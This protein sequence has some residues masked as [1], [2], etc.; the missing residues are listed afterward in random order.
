[1]GELGGGA[2]STRSHRLAV[3]RSMFRALVAEGVLT[4]NPAQAVRCERAVA[5]SVK[6]HVPVPRGQLIKVLAKLG[7]DERGRRDRALLLV[8]ANCGLR[9]SEVAELTVSSIERNGEDAALLVH[10]KGG[11]VDRL[12]LKP[13]T[14]GALEKW[15]EVSGGKDAPDG[16]LFRN[17]S[18]NPKLRAG[19]LSPGGVRVIVRKYFKRF[20]PH[21][22]RSRFVSDVYENA[23]D[24]FMAQLA[25]RHKS[26]QVTQGYISVE[27]Q[28]QAMTFAPNYE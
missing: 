21:S 26:S 11:R 17:I 3:V 27:Q 5:E 25:A 7:D 9:R 23:G 22:M 10:G 4:E 12:P 28:K 16:Y 24:I 6:H 18:R 14:L 19:K 1:M 8:L 20:S 15:L 13:A 2:K